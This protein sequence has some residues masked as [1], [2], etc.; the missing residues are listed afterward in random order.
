MQID[1][2]RKTNNSK[3]KYKYSNEGIRLE[4]LKKETQT[5]INHNFV[6]SQKHKKQASPDTITPPNRYQTPARYNTNPS[7]GVNL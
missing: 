5:K 2:K 3:Q 6:H 1:S 7:P 4:L